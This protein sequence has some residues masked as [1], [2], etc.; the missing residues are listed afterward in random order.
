MHMQ[1]LLLSLHRRSRQSRF[2]RSAMGRRLFEN[3]YLAYKVLLEA[4]PVGRL[5]VYVTPNSTAIDVGA[6]IG[7]FTLRFADWVG[8][9]GRV[10]AIEPEA[11][12][13]TS[14]RRRIDASGNAVRITAIQAVA[15][16]AAGVLYLDVNPDHPG[17]HKIAQQGLATAAVTLDGLSA[18]HGEPIVSLIKIDVQGAEM[19]VLRGAIG[20]LQRCRP[21]LFIEVDDAALR[22]QA[23][24]APELFNHLSSLGYRAYRLRRFGSAKTIAAADIGAGNYQD[25]LFLDD[26]K[27][28]KS[29]AP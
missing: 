13:F 5:R 3:A 1:D 23:S 12:N 11:E 22:K 17:D 7:M 9:H 15:A 10:I 27:S 25:V 21:A 20:I 24:S 14:L 28:D 19:R 16:E 18:E 29:K 26:R 6:N 2:L 4:G 8:D